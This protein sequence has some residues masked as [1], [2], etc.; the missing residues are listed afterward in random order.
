MTAVT[1]K[2]VKRRR[3][4]RGDGE[5]LRAEIVA[6]AKKLLA[7]GERAD[8]VPIRAVADAV[9]V[10]APSIYLHFA[11]KQKL[12]DAVVADVFSELD[13]AM[14]TAGAKETTPLGRLEAFGM[15]YVRFAV[16]HP[17]HYRLALLDPCPGPN[18]EV[19]DV[20]ASS[21]FAHFH[22]TVVECVEAGIFPGADPLATTF[23]LWSAAHGVAALLIAK[24]YLPFGT[25]EDFASRVL[26]A[27]AVGQA[28]RGLLGGDPT[29]AEIT[30]WLAQQ[31]R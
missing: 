19:D 28:V 16:E 20:I 1:A 30:E 3:A 5:Q 13:D 2:T 22:G 4:A 31:D 26:C 24:P 18:I 11:D 17:E 10:T 6:A 9:G 25:V 8:D 29:S 7:E 15:A 23:D 27:A 21:A 12:L 14:V